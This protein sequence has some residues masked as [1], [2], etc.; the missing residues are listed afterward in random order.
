MIV[1]FSLGQHLLENN[2]FCFYK[3]FSLL[4]L[5]SWKLSK[6]VS[7]SRKSSSQFSGQPCSYAVGVLEICAM[8][9]MCLYWFWSLLNVGIGHLVLIH[10]VCDTSKAFAQTFE[11]YVNRLLFTFLICSTVELQFKLH[12]LDCMKHEF[13]CIPLQTWTNP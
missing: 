11:M 1:F 5:F 3:N 12:S 2:D 7:V 4:V 6:F 8:V 13:G 10:S 9:A